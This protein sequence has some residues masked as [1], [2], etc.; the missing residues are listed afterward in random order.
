MARTTDPNRPEFELKILRRAAKVFSEKGYRETTIEDIA[1]N[2]RL[3]KTSIYHYF[4]SKENILFRAISLNLETSLEPLVAVMQEDVPTPTKLKRAIAC[5]V[6]AFL[7]A[8]YFAL[9]FV[10][11]RKFL[12]R[13]HLEICLQLRDRHESIF[14]EIVAGGIRDGSFRD[15][16]H[17]VAVKII[18]GVLNWLPVWWRPSGRYGKDEIIAQINEALVEKMLWPDR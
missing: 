15:T 6:Q 14:R 12:S 16:D 1:R 9:L 10:T 7:D 18:F 2:V 17:A 8:P 11:D 13:K 5:Q 4:R 3:K